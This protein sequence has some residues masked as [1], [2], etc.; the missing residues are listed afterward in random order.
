MFRLYFL[1]VSSISLDFIV[2]VSG[3]CPSNY[4][5]NNNTCYRFSHDKQA[6]VNAEVKL[7]LTC[8]IENY[9]GL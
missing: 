2:L 6:W 8:K 7:L 4:I 5:T 9:L 1:I 3:I